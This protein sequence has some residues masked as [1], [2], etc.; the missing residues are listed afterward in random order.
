[1]GDRG[2]GWP[3]NKGAGGLNDPA[4]GIL[5]HGKDLVGK[6]HE[7]TRAWNDWVAEVSPT[8][9]VGWIRQPKRRR[10][11]T[12]TWAAP[13]ASQAVGSPKMKSSRWFGMLSDMP[14][15]RKKRTR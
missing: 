1:V 13:N 9:L 8:H 12:S 15:D 2:S 11:L 3:R 6:I 4:D 10:T 7:C 5:R 14:R